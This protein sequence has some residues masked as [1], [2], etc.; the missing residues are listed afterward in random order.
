MPFTTPNSA[1]RTSVAGPDSSSTADRTA[2]E[3]RR[4]D[5]GT[6]LLEGLDALVRRHRALL[7][8]GSGTLHAELITAEVAHELAV[9]RSALRRTPQPPSTPE[10]RRVRPFD[11]GVPVAR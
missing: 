11:S 2:L 10:P 8:V 3:Q 5:I 1:P 9:A 4:A 7:S 6:R